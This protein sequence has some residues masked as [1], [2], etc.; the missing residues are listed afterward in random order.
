MILS[1]DTSGRFASSAAIS[2]QGKLIAVKSGSPEKQ[3]SQVILSLCIELLKEQGLELKDMNTFA[4]AAGPGSYTGLRVGIATVKAI[5][6]A[7]K[8][9][10]I[11][12]STLLALAYSVP[13]EGYICSLIHA[14][15]GVS[16][17]ALFSSYDGILTR[18][19]ADKVLTFAE[20]AT[21]LKRYEYE[22][23]TFTGDGA[24][25]FLSSDS[26]SGVTARYSSKEPF[27]A[28]VAAAADIYEPMRPQELQAV[29][30]Q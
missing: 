5:A 20:T 23:I 7:L 18:I 13:A 25:A 12:V 17:G 21:L 10:C 27:A 22:E 29:Y 15:Q 19:T 24:E 2:G 8:K 14:R 9:S 28:A 1:V 4:V 3:H 30:L 26:F 11:G 6:Y 16:Y